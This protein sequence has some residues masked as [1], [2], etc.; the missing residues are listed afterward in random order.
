[1]RSIALVASLMSPAVSLGEDCIQ[2]VDRPRTDQFFYRA[3][4]T[5]GAVGDV[6]GVDLSLTLLD[7]NPHIEGVI[8]WPSAFTLIGCYD[9]QA[10]ELLDVVRYSDFYDEFAFLSVFYPE[11]EGARTWNDPGGGFI[12]SSAM[13]RGAA[14]RFLPPGQAF[15]MATLH[16]RITAM[17][18]QELAV[19]FCDE[20][21]VSISCESNTLSFDRVDRGGVTVLS[22]R[23]VPA[24]ILVLPGDATHPEPPP[25]PPNAAVYTEAPTP[26]SAA[27]RFEL[28]G[29]LVA[30]PGDPDVA[31]DLFITS[32]YEFSGFMTALKFHAEHL[33]LT[34]V[35]EHTRP[36]IGSIDNEA[37]GFGLLM[38]NSRRLVGREGERLRAATLHFRVREE[39]SAA[40]QV[41]I[42]FA[43]F[44]NFFNWLAIQHRQG[45]HQGELPVAADVTPLFIA[46]ALLRIQTQPA[47]L[48][49]VNLDY[50]VN[51]S[52]AVSLLG[53]LFRGER[54]VVC[55]QAADYNE[56]G[57]VNLSDAVAILNALF[58]GG[59]QASDREVTC[60]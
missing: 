26:E 28:D 21:L 46:H 2:G 43:P 27:I 25:I 57:R 8:P 15:P 38:S 16:F 55:P 29:P 3:S 53:T 41:E 18:G 34:G 52:D 40:G 35:E 58:L 50:E 59:P 10:L 60:E 37:G 5:S 51:L 56:D 22:G 6:V 17:P 7:P 48:G 24:V 32:N 47:R 20:K 33:E 19:R 14:E 1:M 49:D 23:H 9:P 54:S 39:A 13:R 12:L 42:R 30:R 31:M 36:G 44:G 11:G 45:Q 4:S